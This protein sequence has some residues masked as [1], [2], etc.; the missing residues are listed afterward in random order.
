MQ[1]VFRFWGFDR[2]AYRRAVGDG[3]PIGLL[4]RPAPAPV[5]ARVEL[6]EELAERCGPLERCC[7]QGWW[8]WLLL[9]RGVRPEGEPLAWWRTADGAAVPLVTRTAAHAFQFWFD[10]DRTLGFIQN[11]R[12]LPHSTPL[13]VR[14]G[15]NPDALPAWMR[16][17]GF[18]VM[19]LA[20]RVH[21]ITGPLFPQ[22]P[23]DPSVDGWRYLIHSIVEESLGAA[24]VPLWPEGKQ[25]AVTLS[26]D[27]DTDY[28]F[29][30]PALLEK[31][32]ALDEAAG[33]RSAWMIVTRLLAA[34]RR[35]LDDL[36]A[37]GHEIGFHDA[38]HDHRLPFLHPVRMA[39]RI[40]EATAL[41]DAYGTTGF[42]SPSYLRSPALYQALDGIL[43]YDM[44]MHDVIEGFCRPRRRHEGCSTCLPFFVEGTDV[45]EI[46]TTVPEDWYFDSQGCA[47]PQ[48][49][50]R[51]QLRSVVS[52]K[53]RGGVAGILTHPEPELA[54]LPDWL[55]IYHEL[56]AQLSGDSEA[57]VARPC[58]INRHWRQRQAMIDQLW[59]TDATSGRA[60][61]REMP[62][63]N[64]IVAAAVGFAAQTLECCA[65]APVDS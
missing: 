3:G 52:I 4:S 29:R 28:C 51:N 30:F 53:Q 48:S 17:L 32:R 8:S 50:L 60:S 9:D 56:L 27:I 58:D 19:H 22:H 23:V 36:Y 59:A 10:V 46:P 16:K 18:R 33:M 38:R 49:V 25:Y 45:L 31:V 5:L 20:R 6:A 12:Y 14:L 64:S 24:G 40:A 1:N 63:A 62:S 65:A 55:D 37:A 42:R 7:A 13:Y 35:A 61:A 26:H 15:V 41:I 11:E 43:Q 34:G 21:R 2:E 47:D 44:S 39:E 57:W 54:T